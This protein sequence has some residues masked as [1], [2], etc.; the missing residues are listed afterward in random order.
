[1]L[2]PAA[3]FSD[4]VLALHVLGAIAGFGV[5]FAY[6]LIQ[7]FA[8]RTNPELTPWLL[9]A[10]RRLGRYLVNPGLTVV[11]LAGIYLA[12]DEHRWSQFFVQWGLGAAVVIGALEGSLII[13]RAERAA[14]AAERDLAASEVPA[15]GTRTSAQ[16][17]PDTLA[18]F[19]QLSLAGWAIQAIVVVTVF[20]MAT[21]AGA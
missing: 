18:A 3:Q 14:R 15:G 8:A 4:F 21:H 19:R 6:P 16:W 12:S 20:L 7:A 11:V 13:P 5:V 2:V 17:A 1:V 9:H 10:R